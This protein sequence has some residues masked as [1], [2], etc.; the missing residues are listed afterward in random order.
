M[1][2]IHL[3][4]EAQFEFIITKLLDMKIIIYCDVRI[5]N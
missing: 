5:S 2:K 3:M 4:N 1:D